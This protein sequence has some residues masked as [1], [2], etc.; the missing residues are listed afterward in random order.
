[1]N[2]ADKSREADMAVRQGI[3]RAS[4]LSGDERAMV[5]SFIVIAEMTYPQGRGLRMLCDTR[6]TPWLFEGMMSQGAQ[7]AFDHFSETHPLDDDD[8]EE[9]EEAVD[10]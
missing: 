2:D 1:M 4:E 3:S 7:M 6:M 8:D 5:K 9:E 10:G